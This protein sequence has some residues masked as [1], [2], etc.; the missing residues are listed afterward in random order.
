MSRVLFTNKLQTFY[1][2][3]KLDIV[4]VFPS[5]KEPLVI[6]DSFFT[7]V[8]QHPATFNNTLHAESGGGGGGGLVGAFSASAFREM[9]LSYSVVGR[10]KFE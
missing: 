3:P 1:P 9:A 6:F 2:P 4:L 10:M 5:I 8:G 7:M